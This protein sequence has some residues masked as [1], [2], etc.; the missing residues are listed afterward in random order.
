MT[1]KLVMFMASGGSVKPKGEVASALSRHNSL[2]HKGQPSK[3]AGG[4]LA[5]VVDAAASGQRLRSALASPVREK[6]DTPMAG[7]I[8]A[9]PAKM[10]R[11]STRRRTRA[12]PVASKA[13]VIPDISPPSGGYLSRK[14]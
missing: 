2:M 3:L 9:S 13:P 12:V 1:K 10:P 4:G 14:V 7:S 8:P 11:V 6:V 5:G